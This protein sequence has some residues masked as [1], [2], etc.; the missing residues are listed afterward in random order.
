MSSLI[1]Q[2][3]SIGGANGNRDE[4]ESPSS[5][6]SCYLRASEKHDLKEICD[7]R[8]HCNHQCCMFTLIGSIKR[9][10]C[11]KAGPALYRSHF[12]KILPAL[13]LLGTLHHVK[14]NRGKAS[15]P[16][17]D[18]KL[19]H[20]GGSSQSFGNRDSF[21]VADVGSDVSTAKKLSKDHSTGFVLAAIAL[22]R[23]HC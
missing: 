1:F 19:G 5:G 13:W 15:S 18:Q 6:R 9:V 8:S 4:T 22:K 17:P 7:I 11:A 16:T 2:D 21:V 3:C 10:C 14:G 20:C 23:S 12:W